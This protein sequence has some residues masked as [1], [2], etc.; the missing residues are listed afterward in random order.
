MWIYPRLLKWVDSWYT[1]M[2]WDGDGMCQYNHG[3]DSGWDNCTYFKIGA[4]I[5]GPDLAA[6][7]AL[8]HFELSECARI[9]GFL[10]DAE[11][12]AARDRA[13]IDRLL[14]HSW[15]GKRFRVLQNG[16]HNEM[17]D[18][19]SLFAY[20]PILL[21]ERLP[22]EVFNALA[23]GIAE[24]DRFI[25]PYGVAT[26][27][28]A[29]KYYTPDGYW[30]GP[31]WAPSTMFIVDGL[32]RGGRH[33]L[34]RGIARN[35]CDNCVKNGFAENF[36]AKTGAGLRDRAYT[37]TSSVFLILAREYLTNSTKETELV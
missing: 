9:L 8:C 5:E 1:Y 19:D 14:A 23:D 20:L 11:S 25:T 27:S 17:E 7:L 31:I 6:Y 24:R 36:N 16:T 35:F 4:P 13:Q 3:N 12:H 33:A 30:M 34:A 2:D 28:L 21:A 18:C 22:R 15:T 29:S 37:W 10:A 26:E 32:Y